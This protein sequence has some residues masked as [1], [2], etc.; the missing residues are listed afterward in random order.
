MAI[1]G[2][3]FGGCFGRNRA[4]GKY[5]LQS[6]HT[7]YRLFRIDGLDKV[8]RS[9][10]QL[11]VNYEQQQE[12]P[13]EPEETQDRLI[14]EGQAEDTAEE[15]DEP[16]AAEEAGPTLAPAA[17]VGGTHQRRGRPRKETV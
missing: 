3:C 12:I 14:T 5:Y 2:E 17:L 7:D 1:G 11:R 8:R 10:G 15:A 6:G 9:E 16:E 13:L 4:D